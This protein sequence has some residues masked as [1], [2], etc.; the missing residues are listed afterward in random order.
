MRDQELYND[1]EL[2]PLGTYAHLKQR[3][4]EMC[5]S[6]DAMLWAEVFVETKKEMHWTLDDIDESLMVGWFANAM[7]AWEWQME[8]DKVAKSKKFWEEFN[9]VDQI[10]DGDHT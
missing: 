5:Q 6:G 1:D 9:R 2:V 4:D 8:R 7:Q 3:Q 10:W